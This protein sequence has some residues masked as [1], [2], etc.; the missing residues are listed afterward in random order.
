MSL[1]IDSVQIARRFQKSIRIDS[2]LGDPASLEGFVCPQSSANA[3][4]SMAETVSESGHGA[5]TWTGPYGSGKSSLVIALSAMLGNDKQALAAAEKAAGKGLVEKI[6]VLLQPKKNGWKI[7]PAVGK[8][9]NPAEVI[10]ESLLEAG[11]EINP[12]SSDNL[13]RHVIQELLRIAADNSRS[14]GGLIVFVDELGKCLE[15]AGSKAQDIYFLQQLAEAASR[16]KKRLIVVG[17]LHQSFGEYASRLSR[18]ARDEWTKIQGRFVDLPINTIGEEQVDLI[19]RA[20]ESS[21][22]DKSIARTSKT[23]F[24]LIKKNRPSAS[25][26]LQSKLEGCWPLH[27]VVAC[28]LGPISKR[29]FGQNQRSIFGF[30]N[31]PEP[32]GFQDYLKNTRLKSHQLYS[33]AALL[34]YLRINLEPSILASP[35]GHRWSL[36]VEAIERCE[37]LGGDA[38]H[39][40]VAKTIALVDLFKNRSGLTASFD[41][42]NACFPKEAKQDIQV[43]LDDLQKWSIVI[44]KK[45]LDSYAVYAGSDFDIDQALNEF[46]ADQKVDFK[47]LRSI[48]QLQP[49]LA[50]RYY[51]LT[52]SLCWFDTDIAPVS[53]AQKR[54]E[55][56]S[57]T[58]GAIGQFLLLIPTEG[59]TAAQ[60]DEICRLA[61]ESGEVW[62]SLL[63][64]AQNSWYV[65]SLAKELIALERIRVERPEL[66]GDAVARREV[67]ARIAATSSVLEEE[68]KKSFSG[69]NWYRKGV[70]P[71]TVGHAGLSFQASMLAREVF[72]SAPRIH[73]ELL[74]RIKPSSNAIAAQK[75]LL[76]LMVSKEGVE[77]LGIEGFPAEGGLFE[78]IL[79]K[80]GLYRQD[81]ES[82]K[83]RFLP[84]RKKDPSRLYPL[85]NAAE[86]FLSRS[87]HQVVSLQNIY[88]IWVKE[89]GVRQGLLP[90]LGVAFILANRN[91]VALYLDGI[92]RSSFDDYAV[93]CLTQDAQRLQL[94][95]MDLPEVSRRILSGM[96]D[97]VAEIDESGE[98][99]DL[100]PIEVAKR[101]VAIVDGLPRWALRTMKVSQNAKQVRDLFK[102][103]HDPNKFLF[104]DMP[105]LFNG[106]SE[107]IDISSADQVITKVREGIVEL[108][109]AYPEMLE[110][111]Q[112]KMLSEL[113]VG[114]NDESLSKLRARAENLREITGNFRLEAF[115]ARLSNFNGHPEEVEGIASLAANKPPRDWIDRDIDQA[116]IEIADLAQQFNR[117]ESFA[118][119]QGRTDARH[120]VAVVVG[121]GK[122][123]RPLAKE[124]EIS[125]QEK[126]AVDQLMKKLQEIIDQEKMPE[127][128][129]LAAMAEISAKYMSEENE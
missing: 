113:N 83:Y 23:V 118:R 101:L 60:T 85:W 91:Q 41:F 27:P 114:S 20:I 8:R 98:Q 72:P 107:S 125:S 14:S 89:F 61:V 100:E 82:G 103:A 56:F 32:Q 40:E 12:G 76:R 121:L 126:K 95:W 97:L 13:D 124:F 71:H 99:V 67:D 6:R 74:N 63:G 38:L 116:T 58:S 47:K 94:R 25:D 104:D 34:D 62:P 112:R 43:V 66:E 16:S 17:V 127:R 35:D 128:L 46:D 86:K 108:K 79:S 55:S 1:L 122:S 78:S 24:S 45:Y 22:N 90:V 109:N 102:Q 18:E 7:L 15:D 115:I 29:R 9:A 69:A 77:R 64:I 37:A 11:Y 123:P 53:E 19:S 93:D 117:T 42:I 68:L 52:G 30:L 48:A 51:H 70:E 2:D 87:S 36:A 31:S 105:S 111:L 4:M 75:A 59:E 57:P 92:F 21:H 5:F 39:V 88:D 26:D 120:A 80:T 44:F 96:A 50:K 28:L 110:G 54:V 65:E 106:E 3:L 49:V 73:N 10:Y 129:A 33:P 119:V 84:P 81:K